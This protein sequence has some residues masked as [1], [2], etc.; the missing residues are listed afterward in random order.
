LRFELP[1]SGA[2]SID[3]LDVLGRETGDRIEGWWPAGPHE[4]AMDAR[5]LSP[6]V[7]SALLTAGG[8]HEVLRLVHV[9]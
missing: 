6:G 8:A 3:V 5:R 2:V 9:R 1:R 4:V 7:Y